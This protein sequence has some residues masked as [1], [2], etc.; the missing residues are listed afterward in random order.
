MALAIWWRGDALPSLTPVV[1][2]HVEASRDAS[3]IAHVTGL[4]GRQQ[5][6]TVRVP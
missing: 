1:G 6:R 2:F 3:L 4:Q 5:P